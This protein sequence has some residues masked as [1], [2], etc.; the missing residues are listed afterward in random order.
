[1]WSDRKRAFLLKPRGA[2][3]ARYGKSFPLLTRPTTGGERSGTRFL[4]TEVHVCPPAD[5]PV[6]CSY[7]VFRCAR[8]AAGQGPDGVVY[9]S[10]RMLP[11]LLTSPASFFLF[12]LFGL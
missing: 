8:S 10:G 11:I 2:K 7:S 9:T 6:C 4:S 3:G 5:L 1:M 12:W